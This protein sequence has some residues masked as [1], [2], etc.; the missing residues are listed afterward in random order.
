MH[1]EIII[2]DEFENSEDA[3]DIDH[4]KSAEEIETETLF[5]DCDQ[6]ANQYE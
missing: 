4:K 6:M 5:A 1:R 2:N 3:E